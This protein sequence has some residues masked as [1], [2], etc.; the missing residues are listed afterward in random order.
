MERHNFWRLL[1][2]YRIIF[3]LIQRDYAQGRTDYHSSGIRKRFLASLLQAVRNNADQKPLMLGYIFGR[4]DGD[5]FIPFDGQQRLC[6]LFLLYLYAAIKD[7]AFKEVSI[8]KVFHK[9]GYEA[10]EES[11][12]FL[13]KLLADLAN[14]SDNEMG[15]LISSPETGALIADYAKKQPWFSPMWHWD[16]SICGFLVTLDEI[17][18]AFA[19]CEGLW[20]V[21][22]N[23][24]NP[25]IQFY[26]ANIED[27]D[28]S[29]D[30]LFIKMNSRGKGLGHFEKFKASFLEWLKWEAPEKVESI[31]R[32]LD[33]DWQNLFWKAFGKD[34]DGD[35]VLHTDSCFYNFLAW[36]A[37]ILFHSSNPGG[38]D[39]PSGKELLDVMIEA[40]QREQY[41]QAPES[42]ISFLENALDSLVLLEQYKGIA[43]YLDSIFLFA[44]DGTMP[45]P[46]KISLF[47]EMDMFSEI[48]TRGKVD[49]TA[50]LMFFGFLIQLIHN[51]K[52]SNPVLD[53][54]Q[55]RLL[56]DRE[57][58]QQLR[59]LRNLIENSKEELNNASLALQLE[60]ISRLIRKELRTGL[61]AFNAFQLE[62]EK[63]K[64][65]ALCQ[66][67]ALAAD[68]EWLENHP[69][70]HGCAAIFSEPN[71]RRN[72][73]KFS[74]YALKTGKNFFE[75]ALGKN[76]LAWD[77]LVQGF[78][79][80]NIFGLREGSLS[81]KY[82]YLGKDDNEGRRKI[83]TTSRADCFSEIRDAVQKLGEKIGADNGYSMESVIG[84]IVFK[85][86]EKCRME[87]KMDWRWYFVAYPEI[88]PAY[89]QTDGYY[90]W[91]Y[92]WR[93]FEQRQLRKQIMKGPHKNPFLWAVYVEAGFC[94]SDR[95]RGRAMFRE[96]S[97][98]GKDN[99]IAFPASRLGL[100]GGELYWRAY[101][102]QGRP[103][104]K[105]QQNFLNDLRTRLKNK[106]IIMNQDGYCFIA[107]RDSRKW[108][109][110]NFS[111]EDTA[112][113]IRKYDRQDR[114]ELGKKIALEMLEQA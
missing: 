47:H 15:K 12:E 37:H 92:S 36:F 75:R 34:Y 106:G 96:E 87:G 50:S 64:M 20:H 85:W 31:A 95:N 38:K 16:Q 100:W 25:P 111:L 94:D 26:F 32:K 30:D 52:T 4:S 69:L 9:L 98:K 70:L 91:D 44:P 68:L 5:Q 19:K 107:G 21:L 86:I 13:E 101:S 59:M 84:K 71:S 11:S 6:T 76:P 55:A 2:N 102:M 73:L 33:T 14:S 42:N 24:Q 90:D 61:H 66:D 48:C 3:P 89:C 110:N 60:G 10:R 114:I 63:A 40:L 27:F 56:P 46:G 49:G 23:E 8:Q 79:T 99:P 72:K 65:D 57:Q 41:L 35:K 112:D 83:F 62:E 51:L 67:P 39:H 104:G 29:A 58:L 81:N 103:P 97:G 82:F 17:R 88:L 45:E 93:S 53:D 74:A 80:Q 108:N 28:A 105:R 18:Q 113:I 43:E 1:Q 22:V 7:G 77:K 109:P 78:L 54:V